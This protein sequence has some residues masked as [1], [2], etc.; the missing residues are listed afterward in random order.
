MLRQDRNSLVL[1]HFID[2]VSSILLGILARCRINS[3]VQAYWENAWTNPAL[4]HLFRVQATRLWKAPVTAKAEGLCCGCWG[5]T[6]VS[7]M[8]HIAAV[9]F[10]YRKCKAPSDQKAAY[11]KHLG[12][13]SSLMKTMV[14]AIIIFFIRA[15]AAAAAAHHHIS[16]HHG[17]RAHPLAST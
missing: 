5:S 10:A 4:S 1:S 7:S 3:Q 11:S 6:A 14:A 16:Q 13:H 17:Y 8:Q 9:G 12:H 2:R 15:C